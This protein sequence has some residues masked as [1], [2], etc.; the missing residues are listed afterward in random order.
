MDSTL[1]KSLIVVKGE[2]LKGFEMERGRDRKS[3]T[4]IGVTGAKPGYLDHGPY[5][6]S[7]VQNQRP[8]NHVQ[9]VESTSGF[10]R[11]DLG[12]LFSSE[13]AGAA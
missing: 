4:V 1:H 9:T 12:E 10:R 7:Q 8:V 2:Y 13:F 3:V 6:G 11:M 5:G